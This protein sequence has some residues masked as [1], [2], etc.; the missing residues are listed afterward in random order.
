M[1]YGRSH[2][3]TLSQG[4]EMISIVPPKR[5]LRLQLEELARGA[6]YIA[7]MERGDRGVMVRTFGRSGRGGSLDVVL[8]M[9]HEEMLRLK[10]LVVRRRYCIVEKHWLPGTYLSTHPFLSASQAGD[11]Q[12][13]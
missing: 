6:T 12:L 3:N 11:Y 13:Q 2:R 1:K 7:M 8:G 4:Y 9:T 5:Q 10:E